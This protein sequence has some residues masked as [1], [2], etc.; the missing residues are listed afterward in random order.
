MDGLFVHLNKIDFHIFNNQQFHTRRCQVLFQFIVKGGIT[1]ENDRFQLTWCCKIS[2]RTDTDLTL[3]IEIQ[4]D[5]KSRDISQKETPLKLAY[6]FFNNCLIS[7]DFILKKLFT[8]L[9][10]QYSAG[11]I[12]PGTTS[13]SSNSCILGRLLG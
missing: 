12:R 11:V 4:F 2:S 1:S 5:T 7:F 10:Y 13:F 9:F 8:V 3:S 6:L